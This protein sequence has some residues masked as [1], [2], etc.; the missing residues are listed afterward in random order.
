M[1]T[2]RSMNHVVGIAHLSYKSYRSSFNYQEMCWWAMPT[3][4]L[5]IL[6]NLFFQI[7]HHHPKILDISLP[8][9]HDEKLNIAN[10]QHD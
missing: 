10:Q 6:Q 1:K 9:H 3:L 8:L 2:I 7:P 4:P 5:I